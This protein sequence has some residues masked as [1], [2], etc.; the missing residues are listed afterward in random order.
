[1][2]PTIIAATLFVASLYV[3]G[4]YGEIEEKPEKLDLDT[5]DPNKGEGRKRQVVRSYTRTV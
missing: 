3:V 4:R 2:F 1:M 5:V